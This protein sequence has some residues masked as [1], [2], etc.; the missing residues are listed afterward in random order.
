[1]IFYI[2]LSFFQHCQT[3]LFYIFTL[4]ENKEPISKIVIM[5]GGADRGDECGMLAVSAVISVMT[6]SSAQEGHAATLR[7]HCCF[8]GH[9]E[10]PPH[11]KTYVASDPA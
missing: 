5:S 7:D 11:T 8:A 4:A 10:L 9:W 3:W 1:M 2:L 6:P